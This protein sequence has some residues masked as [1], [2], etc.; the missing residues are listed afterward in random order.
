M[1]YA[2]HSD[3]SSHDQ[4]TVYLLAQF[5][6]FKCKLVS[7]SQIYL[8]KVKAVYMLSASLADRFH[9]KSDFDFTSHLDLN[10]NLDSNF[11]LDLPFT[12]VAHDWK[13]FICY[14]HHWE[15]AFILILTSTSHLDLNL[16]LDS[17]YNFNFN[18]SRTR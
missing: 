4:S 16:N 15:T 12:I 10:L 9:C 14:V 8:V 1:L 2:P 11:N 3:S 13:P 17:N 6:C 7:N 18:K 5:L